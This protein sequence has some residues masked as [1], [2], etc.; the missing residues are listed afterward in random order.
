MRFWKRSARA[1]RSLSST[2]RTR[3][4]NR[5]NVA[6]EHLEPRQLLT[7]EST[8]SSLAGSAAA[9]DL[10]VLPEASSG[11]SGYSP[12]QIQNAYGINGITFAGGAITGN[13]AGQTIA[14]VDAYGDPTIASDLAKFDSEY[15][16]S[17]PPSFTV[18]NLGATTTNAG[19]ALETA[20]DVEWAHAIAPRA[21][22]VLV[23]A[24]SS[25]LD[26]LFN[27]VNDAR[28]LPG[29]SVVSMSWGTQEFWGESQYD[30]LFTTPAGHTGVTFV[31]ASGDDGAW[32]GPLYPSVSPNVLAVGGTTLTLGPNNTYGSET[33]WS[34]ST[35]GFS[36]TDSEFWSYESTP[37]Y[38]IAAQQASGL[39]FGVRTTPDVSFNADPNT[40]VS[41]YDSVPYDG[42]VGWFDVGGTSAAAPAWAGLVAI[43]DQ[44]LATTGEGSL[45]ST[46]LLTDLYSLPSSDYHDITSGSNGYPATSGYDLVTGLGSPKANLVV[47]GLVSDGGVSTASVNGTSTIA[48]N[49]ASGRSSSREVAVAAAAVV[50]PAAS[51]S[52]TSVGVL[53][54]AQPS[55]GQNSSSA[56][57]NASA[58]AATSTSTPGGASDSASVTTLGQSLT[59]TA[60]TV[61]TQTDDETQAVPVADEAS[62]MPAATDWGRQQ[63][64]PL[65]LPASDSGSDAITPRSA[66]PAIDPQ[67]PTTPKPAPSE[68]SSA[69]F[70]LALESLGQVTDAVEDESATRRSARNRKPAGFAMAGRFSTLLG[71]VALASGGYWLAM[72]E[73]R[74]TQRRWLPGR[75]LPS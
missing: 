6:C 61:S 50:P 40:G 3:P 67:V 21:N 72:R 25:N 4:G 65:S 59:P 24:A 55:P 68:A 51:P 58:A 47:A 63:G 9:V 66:A 62:T 60:S 14:I 31:A 69:C 35:G 53:I 43:A 28:Q 16:L 20:L 13:G 34:G 8:V 70:D 38:Q 32:S 48:L 23:E 71:A 22:I 17:A 27:A 42:S 74:G 57:T 12:Q 45:T 73:P 46:Q 5:V 29:V 36:G 44:G 26:S 56:G 30:S 39:S 1:T 11:P 49:T 33:A 37:S 75:K 7:V 52:V 54:G 10:V 2:F 64:E 18:D 19:W 15:G 41:V